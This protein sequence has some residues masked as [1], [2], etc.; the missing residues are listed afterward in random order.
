MTNQNLAPY[1]ID[2]KSSKGTRFIEND[3][4]LKYRSIF[5][6]DRHKI[7]NSASF[8]RLQYKTQVFVNHEGDHYRTRLTHSLEVAQ[9]ARLIAGALLVNQD[10]AEI[11]SLAHDLGHSPFGHAGE[12]ALNEK[13]LELKFFD[14]KFLHNEHGLKLITKLEKISPEFDGLNLSWETLEGIIKHN[15]PILN[16]KSQYILNYNKEF[17]LDLKN[18]SS[19][20]AQI[21]AISDDIAYNNHDLEDGLRAELFKIEDLFEL[22]LIGN[23]Y[24]NILQKNPK[25]R[26]ELLVS[27][28][29]KQ[30]TAIMALD[31]IENSKKNI[32]QNNIKNSQDARNLKKSLVG[33]SKEVEKAHQELKKFLMK[34]MYRHQKVNQMTIDA[35]NIISK[36][37]D[38]YANNENEFLAKIDINLTLKNISK[39]QMAILVCDY[40][41]GMTDRFAIKEFKK[42]IK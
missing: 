12:D 33:F 38:Y 16:D 41:A 10:L 14:L 24:Q 6:V 30:I 40:I 28:A 17:D 34:N 23:I 3:E 22:N 15:G 5:A 39:K 32:A 8:R 31:V 27:E 13:L 1:A 2:E 20:E 37:F 4:T 9:I 25:L 42:L 18:Y 36:L 29:K 11:I 19:I 21:S 26:R 7:I 35:K